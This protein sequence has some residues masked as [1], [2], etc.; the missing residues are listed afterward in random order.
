MQT[1]A[2]YRGAIKQKNAK[3]QDSHK[4]R[5]KGNRTSSAKSSFWRRLGN[6]TGFG[7]GELAQRSCLRILE[8]QQHFEAESIE[9]IEFIIVSINGRAFTNNAVSSPFRFATDSATIFS[10]NDTSTNRDGFVCW[11]GDV[12]KFDLLELDG[13]IVTETLLWTMFPDLLEFNFCVQDFVGTDFSLGFTPIS[14]A[15]WL[16]IV[17][18]YKIHSFEFFQLSIA[19][20]QAF[21]SF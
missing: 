16:E 12:K 6:E 3:L 7:D 4:V 8:R 9:N 13:I 14:E 11:Y 17:R 10:L 1:P 20:A 19:R 18:A 2:K 15:A 21:Q 5:P